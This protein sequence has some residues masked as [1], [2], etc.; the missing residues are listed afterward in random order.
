MITRLVF[1]PVG[2]KKTSKNKKTKTKK[3]NIYIE[4]HETP[5]SDEMFL[6]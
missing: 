3:K 5:S 1:R 2:K 6:N 4:K